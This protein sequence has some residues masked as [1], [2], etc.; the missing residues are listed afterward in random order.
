MAIVTLGIDL[1][2]NVFALHGVGST[3]KPELV[4]PEIRRSRL[5]ELV[6]SLP[7]CLIGMETCSGAHHWAREFE[8][9][10]HTVRL[11]APKFVAPYR[12]AGKRGKNDA[13]DAAA[14]CEAVTRPNMR[15]V[16]IKTIDQQAELFVHRAR[17][18]YI[19]ERTA[20]INR[21]RGLLS[22][23]GIA[24][25]LKASLM[26]R[27]IHSILEDLPGWCNV[28][29]GDM[30]VHLADLDE[31]IATYDRHVAKI[32]KQ[33][34]R[35]RLLMKLAGVGPTTA[36]AIVASIGNGH[37]F[38]NSRQFCAWL[39]LT[40]GQHSSGGKA[41]LGSITKAG[42]AYLRTLLVMGARSLLMKA[43]NHTDSVSRWAI[44]LKERRGFGR[45]VVAIVA[46]N[47]RMCW[48]ALRLGESFRVPT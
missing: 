45:A 33:N 12:M 19:E 24:L 5:L 6:G 10:G 43:A 38:K 28:V 9:L 41:R 26:R 7:P 16:P 47:A 25:P 17:Q 1:A 14:I 27:D 29:V 18:G 8:K 22:E 40:L 11:M 23:L 35:A 39:G 36:S 20:L 15:F 42:D 34:D 13:N 32:A 3:G 46:K 37:D 31:R 44:K 4:R 30:L 2:K 48:A 21:L